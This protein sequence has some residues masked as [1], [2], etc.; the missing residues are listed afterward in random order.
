[1]RNLTVRRKWLRVAGGG[2]PLLASRPASSGTKLVTPEQPEG[3][4]YPVTGRAEKDVD[5]TRV[6]GVP[7]RARGTIVHLHGSVRTVDVHVRRLRLN[8]GEWADQIETVPGFGYR[9]RR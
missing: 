4:F 3:P 5:L 1:M 9:A 2:I 6:E 7:G 8:L